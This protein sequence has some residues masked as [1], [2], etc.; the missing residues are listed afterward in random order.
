MFSVVS[1]PATPYTSPQG[2]SVHGIIQ[3][4]IL[5]RVAMSSS[6]DSSRPRDRTW[7]SCIGRWILY[8][9]ALPGKLYVNI[10]NV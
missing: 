7:V 8:Q 1:D 3:A 6:G 9:G 2:S 5:E 4:R 10:C